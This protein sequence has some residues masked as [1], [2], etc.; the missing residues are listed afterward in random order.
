MPTNQLNMTSALHRGDKIDKYDV[1]E[2][3]GVG[4]F[5]VVWKA[6]D[7]LLDQ[8]VAVKQLVSDG[9]TD[10][11][12]FRERFRREAAIQK[13]VS[14]SHK[15]LV[16]V[17]DFIEE[18]RGLFIVME[19]VDGMSL[20]HLLAS[21]PGPMDVK[22]ALGI[23]A[24]T[25]LALGG[26]HDQG[27][28][29]RDLKPANVLLP[30]QG[31]LKLCDFG[32]STLM[33]DQ[34]QPAVGTVRYMAPELLLN[35]KADGRADLYSL[36]FML[37]E[38]L[39]GRANFEDAFKVVLRDQR[40][41]SLRWMKW[42]TNLKVKA[43][44]LRQYVPAIPQPI[45]ELVERMIEKDPGQRIATAGQLIDAMKRQL[46]GAPSAVATPA[47]PLAT[48]ASLTA[49]GGDKTAR[50]PKKNKLVYII[51]GTV[52]LWSLI[53]IGWL[54]YDQSQKNKAKAAAESIVMDD[55]R[56]AQDLLKKEDWDSAQ[57]AF[58]S[59]LDNHRGHF[60]MG[61]PV[62]G[63]RRVPLETASKAYAHFAAAMN[64]LKAGRH[65]LSV[66]EFTKAEELEVINRTTLSKALEDAQRGLMYQNIEDKIKRY[67]TE[68]K[69]G[70]AQLE[71]TK[72]MRDSG[73]S[74]T[75]EQRDHW[76]SIG[77]QIQA[78]MD[79]KEA[80]EVLDLSG[81]AE[82][83]GD[84]ARAVE[85]IE[86]WVRKN[87]DKDNRAIKNKLASL[88]GEANFDILVDR[89]KAAVQ[90]GDL[91][92]A[93]DSYTQAIAANTI[94]A[95]QMKFPSEVRRLKSKLAF[96]LGV[97]A[98]E[99]GRIDDAIKYWTD[100][101]A[102]DP[103]NPDPPRELSALDNAAKIAQLKRQAVAAFDNKEYDKSINLWKE[104]R[105]KYNEDPATIA[106]EVAKCEL[107]LAKQALEKAWASED[108]EAA[109]KAADVVT[110]LD[111]GNERAKSIRELIQTRKRF[112]ATVSSGDKAKERGEYGEAKR[113]YREA[114][115]IASTIAD[116]L[117][118]D[119]LVAKANAQLDEAEYIDSF[120]K[121]KKCFELDQL[122]E[123]LGWAKGAVKTKATPEAKSLLAKI[124][125]AAARKQSESEK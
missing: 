65:Q 54:L 110:N 26:I 7:K 30:K 83:S 12:A 20:E 43:P 114:R 94:K 71:H 23:A 2:Q 25:A 108:D 41:Q 111:A 33:A 38:M 4:G 13:K 32:L 10:E 89:A 120:T 63:N 47:A 64:H 55:F 98:K 97:K 96:A 125:V 82:V 51:A 5:S 124:E 29:H 56:A 104:L 92:R 39:L 48:G 22:T 99:G 28:I 46:S 90:N 115:K 119:E 74:L 88:L 72:F 113:E 61:V 44:P 42:H 87:P 79:A 102:E 107:E 81:K 118:K 78:Q 3:I 80:A 106:G 35:Q 8:W 75:G 103:T 93:I 14:Q 31:G 6:H 62:Y 57:R 59:I 11:D 17:I 9:T 19:Y 112:R 49:P 122:N 40:N 73:K 68:E 52:L 24:A 34:E 1:A 77:Q 18:P 67:L 117:I 37:Y 60:Q 105:D 100:A 101:A 15:S 66:A 45:A 76:L 91:P 85:I 86:D 36:G 70:Y 58:D 109:V 27:I 84:R 95:E 121:A 21:N 50:I 123:A 16:R 116:A 53:G 69:L